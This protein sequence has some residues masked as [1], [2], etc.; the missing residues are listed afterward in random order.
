MTRALLFMIGLVVLIIAVVIFVT[1]PGCSTVPAAVNAYCATATE[2]ER[3]AM[4]ERF[5]AQIQPHE[6]WVHC[7]D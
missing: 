4:R 1:L 3:A 5:N 7:H 2:S 6:L